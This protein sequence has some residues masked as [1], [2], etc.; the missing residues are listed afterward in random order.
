MMRHQTAEKWKKKYD[1]LTTLVRE[2]VTE[3]SLTR[4]VNAYASLDLVDGRKTWRLL[5]N[6]TGVELR[7]IAA[8][9]QTEN[10]PIILT[11]KGQSH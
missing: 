6:L 1:K 4:W 11:A 9:L 3:E 8:P 10:G 5:N 7:K 2:M